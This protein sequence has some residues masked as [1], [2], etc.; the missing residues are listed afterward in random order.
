[1]SKLIFNK[2]RFT[3]IEIREKNKFD[4]I[5]VVRFLKNPIRA[6]KNST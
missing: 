2:A 1:M 6:N 5:R 3:G 4:L